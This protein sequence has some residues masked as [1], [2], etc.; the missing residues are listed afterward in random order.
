MQTRI[1]GFAIALALMVL[2]P[3]AAGIEMKVL[4]S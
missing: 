1:I 2:I 3:M 4:G